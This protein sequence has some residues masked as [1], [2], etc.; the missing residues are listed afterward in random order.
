MGKRQTNA[1]A[2]SI[3]A[4]VHRNSAILLDD[5]APAFCIERFRRLIINNSNVDRLGEERVV[6]FSQPVHESSATH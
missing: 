2:G 5:H 1:A 4:T 6:V 3:T